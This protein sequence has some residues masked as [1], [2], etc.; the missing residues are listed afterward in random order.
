MGNKRRIMALI[1]FTN[2]LKGAKKPVI[3]RGF[4]DAKSV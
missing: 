4:P 3:D 1:T 2:A